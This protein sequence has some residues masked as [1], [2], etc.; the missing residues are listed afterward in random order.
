MSM[1]VVATPIFC[2]NIYFLS[3]TQNDICIRFYTYK[4]KWK[5]IYTHAIQKKRKQFRMEALVKCTHN[6]NIKEEQFY[7][8]YIMIMNS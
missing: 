6:K 2:D 7:I 1:N 3:E 5:E 4:D 8:L